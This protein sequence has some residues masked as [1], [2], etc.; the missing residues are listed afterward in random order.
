VRY[1]QVTPLLLNEFSK[2]HT[3]LEQQESTT[4][5]QQR[6]IQ[7]LEA[8]WTGRLPKSKKCAKKLHQTRHL[9]RTAPN[10][11]QDGLGVRTA[12]SRSRL[13]IS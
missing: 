13:S 4:I 5:C 12:D 10:D 7:A 6:R 8:G 1:D 3:K 11:P 9:R 2:A